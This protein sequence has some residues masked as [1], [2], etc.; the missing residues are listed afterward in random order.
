MNAARGRTVTKRDIQAYVDGQLDP[1]TEYAEAV[2]AHLAAHSGA[3][4]RVRTYRRQDEAI[5]ARYQEV[6]G[7]PVPDRLTPEAI[8][9]AR[10]EED[11][12]YLPLS[13]RYAAGVAVL[14]CAVL[15][16]WLA[17]QPANRPLE[18]FATGRRR[19]WVGTVMWR[20]LAPR[21][22]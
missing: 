6:L 1:G 19:S 21:R 17:G 15:I 4:A 10:K 11:G 13:V 7:Q 5:R 8:R 22:H 16:G 20:P 14:S 9:A 2:E 18:R 12:R 3:R